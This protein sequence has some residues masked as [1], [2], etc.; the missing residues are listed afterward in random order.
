MDGDMTNGEM[1]ALLGLDA[2]AERALDLCH[3]DGQMWGNLPP[4]TREVYLDLAL[5]ELAAE[6]GSE[7][8]L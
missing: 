6:A 3:N 7:G 5:G 4:S 1:R 8:L 2:L